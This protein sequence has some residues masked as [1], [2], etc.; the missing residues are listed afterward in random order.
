MSQT[1]KNVLIGILSF[2]GVLLVAEAMTD[3]YK[4]NHYTQKEI[5]QDPGGPRR[6]TQFN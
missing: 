3:V 5:E 4:F 6:R 1:V 2:V